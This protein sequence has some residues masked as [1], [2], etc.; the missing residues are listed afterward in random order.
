MSKTLKY[1]I[2]RLESSRRAQGQPIDDFF[3]IPY[4][5]SHEDALIEYQRQHP[6]CDLDKVIFVEGVSP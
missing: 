1:R 5:M 2:E 4:D 6:G 3:I